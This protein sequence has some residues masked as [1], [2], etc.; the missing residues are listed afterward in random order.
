MLP[1]IIAITAFTLTLTSSWVEPSTS[2]CISTLPSLS[3]CRNCGSS[4]RYITATLGFSTLV[5]K[6]IANSLR[7]PS[8]GRSR[9][10][11]GERPPGFSACQARY[12]RY[13][14]P[15]MRSAS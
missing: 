11:N 10:A 12:S 6:P 5:R 13:S 14:A 15:P 8:T 9:T 1:A 2:D 4:D 3:G 7:G